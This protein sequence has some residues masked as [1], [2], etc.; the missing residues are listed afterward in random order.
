MKILGISLVSI[1]IVIWSIVG[2][3]IISTR[4]MAI[5][6]TQEQIN[7]A[8]EYFNYDF[9]LAPDKEQQI[10]DINDLYGKDKNIKFE[11]INDLYGICNIMTRQVILDTELPRNMTAITLAHEFEHLNFV[12]S[13]YKANY[14]AIIKL[15]E[16]DKPYLVYQANLLA[17]TILLGGVSAEYDCTELLVKYKESL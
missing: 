5:T 12:I 1:C 10:K 17:K 11:D 7:S 4:P 2:V 13:E 8:I 14:N 9:V 3:L 15:L 6:Y 16:S